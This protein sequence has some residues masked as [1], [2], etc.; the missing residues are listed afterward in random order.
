V[1][2]ARVGLEVMKG[3]E[4][5]ELI[6]DRWV[7]H[8]AVVASYFA[9][10]V[11]KG[12]AGIMLGSPPLINDALHG[13]LDIVEHGL[14]AWVGRHARKAREAL[15]P[16]G[17]K[18]LLDVVG[19][20]I[21]L[22]IAGLALKCLQDAIAALWAILETF[23]GLSAKLPFFLVAML[24]TSAIGATDGKIWLV[25]VI[26]I[27]CASVSLVIYRI[28]TTLARKHRL[29]EY[30]DDAME[31]RQDA[32]LELA[33]GICVLFA[34]GL[35]LLLRYGFGISGSF[36][37][38]NAGAQAVV[39]V[40]LSGY[41]GYHAFHAIRE[42]V[43]NLLHPG[44]DSD[45]AA[46]LRGHVERSLPAGCALADSEEE[47][48]LA[49]KTGEVLYVSGVIRI[50]RLQMLSSDMIVRH[51]EHLAKQFLRLFAEESSVRFFSCT[52]E[53]RCDDAENEWRRIIE[54]VW[55]VAPSGALWEQF[56]AFK[57]GNLTALSSIEPLTP[58]S[59]DNSA[60]LTCW[61]RASGDLFHGGPTASATEA[62][63]T[64]IQDM[65][66]TL[67]EHDPRRLPFRCWQLVRGIMSGDIYNG[68]MPEEVPAV[69]ELITATATPRTGIP[70]VV[71]AEA[72]FALG[73]LRERQPSFD[74]ESS[75]RHYRKALSLY[76]EAGYPL[77]SD[78]L[79]N[80]WGHQKGL[81]YEIEESLYLLNQSRLM[82]EVKGDQVGLAFTCGCLGDTH[83][84]AGSCD[85]AV[86]AYQSDIDICTRL[87][88]SDAMTSVKC[89][90]SEAHICWGVISRDREKIEAA[91]G[92]LRELLK[93]ACGRRQDAFFVRKALTKGLLWKSLLSVGEERSVALKDAEVVLAETDPFSPYTTALW[94]R[95]KGRVAYLGAEIDS[96]MDFQ[97]KARDG[98]ESMSVGVSI[99]LNSL[100]AVCCFVEM[101][102][103]Q[104]GRRPQEM[105]DACDSVQ[106]FSDN[107]GGLLGPARERLDQYVS[108]I[109]DPKA[110]RD[111]FT[112]AVHALLALTEG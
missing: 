86:Q 71:L 66:S 91:I 98:F 105:Y 12:V 65:L 60:L 57:R 15:Y 8:A 74:L 24:P 70:L 73:L 27:S 101:A 25:G 22:G 6:R 84:R 11:T 51:A 17:R 38:I 61:L 62:S 89:K 18:P 93:A 45:T 64:V 67:T 31:L 103:Y 69:R 47:R 20:V 49:Y 32:T 33:T 54:D 96:A 21:G 53:W 29:K 88:L 3:V 112:Q 37:V 44:L 10:A 30:V 19:L 80:T 97:K 87:K 110:G 102:M 1:D 72:H 14:I 39:L 9:K 75:D 85:L 68:S 104:A 40:F 90:L 23:L 5:R 63:A 26:F 107:L 7:I 76:I 43:H 95:L 36:W 56:L 58:A 78:R 99:R 13:A 94:H 50:P 82:K 79:L 2:K 28:E 52:Y 16:L 108:I 81:L 35:I 77:E 55:Q 48:L 59:T 106:R 4:S 109:R 34:W 100:Q 92:A 46:L 111:T 42:N 83:R 41:L